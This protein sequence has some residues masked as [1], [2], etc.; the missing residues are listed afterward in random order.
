[1]IIATS[2]EGNSIDYNRIISSTSSNSVVAAD[3]K[4]FR[5]T[6]LPVDNRLR[7][8]FI[9]DKDNLVALIWDS[10][11]LKT[12]VATLNLAIP[13]ITYKPSLPI[14]NNMLTCVFVSPSVYYTP[15]YGGNFYKDYTNSVFLNIGYMQGI[16]YSSDMTLNSCYTM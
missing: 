3:S 1:M 14:I 8:L 16:V 7:G 15:S 11:L 2:G 5:H 6:A 13:S 4:T 9:I 12:D 10:T